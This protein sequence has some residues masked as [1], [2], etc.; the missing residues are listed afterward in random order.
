LR[1][2]SSLTRWPLFIAYCIFLYLVFTLPLDQIPPAVAQANDKLLHFL[3]FFILTLLGFRTF[4]Q[5]SFPFL[6]QKARIH[7]VIFSIAY[8]VFL[9]WSQEGVPG[10]AASLTDGLADTLGTFA[11]SLI[12][13]MGASPV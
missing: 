11:A 5:S 2:L 7:S 8:A 6:S 1:I 10:R 12:S 3:D 4:S 13:R 9:E